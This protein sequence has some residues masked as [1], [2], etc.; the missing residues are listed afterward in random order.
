MRKSLERNMYRRI[1]YI[2]EYSPIQAKKLATT[3][4]WETSKEL[5]LLYEI[6]QRTKP[7]VFLGLNKSFSENWR[8]GEGSLLCSSGF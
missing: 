7:A 2:I 6:N 3:L 8:D 1:Y 4:H 5:S